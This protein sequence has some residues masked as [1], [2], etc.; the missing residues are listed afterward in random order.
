MSGQLKQPVKHGVARVPLVMQLE[1]LECGAAS[2]TMILAYYGRWIPLEQVRADCGVSRDG[3]NA[4]NIVKCARLHGLEAAGYRYEPEALRKHG[5][6]PCIIHWNFNH[7]VVLTGIRGKRVYIN[8]PAKGSYVVDWK[9]FDS[10]FTGICLQFAPGENFVP[11]GKPKSILAFAAKRLKGTG[12]AIAFT[13]ITGVIAALMNAISPAFSRVFLDRLI[14]HRN[15]DWVVPFLI[16]LA[17]FN[18]VN[19]TMSALQS[20]YGLR[21]KGKMAAV[22]NSSYL[23]KVLHLPME[24]FSQRMSGDIQSRQAANISI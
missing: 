3:S 14:T 4:K 23:W 5:S 20:V 16:L 12:N 13:V 1:T 15:P 11:T 9:T 8:D 10:S 19:I 22:G 2:L 17:V 7:F 6:F 18:L 21:L 24:F